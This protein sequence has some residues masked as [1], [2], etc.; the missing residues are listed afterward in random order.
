[1]TRPRATDFAEN[2]ARAIDVAA[3]L[4]ANSIGHLLSIFASPGSG[5]F[6]LRSIVD[7]SPRL[8][9]A[10]STTMLLARNLP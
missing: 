5:G 4:A 6:P 2:A 10:E 1:M 7:G 8:N 9:P 3:V